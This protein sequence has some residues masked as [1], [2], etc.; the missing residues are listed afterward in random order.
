[1]ISKC[2]RGQTVKVPRIEGFWIWRHPSPVR[3]PVVKIINHVNSIGFVI[4]RRSCVHQNDIL[5]RSVVKWLGFLR[6]NFRRERI[7]CADLEVCQNYREREF[8]TIVQIWSLYYTNDAQ[9]T[10]PGF[11]LSFLKSAW[12]LVYP[13]QSR[14]VK[15]NFKKSDWLSPG[16]VY[17]TFWNFFFILIKTCFL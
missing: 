16:L 9:Y 15:L 14:D 5:V 3:P 7:Q 17:K 12:D 11:R 13:G 2:I 1:M 4:L 10:N 6:S 8:R